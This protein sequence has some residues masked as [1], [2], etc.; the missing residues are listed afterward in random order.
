MGYR[1]LR[2]I[3]EVSFV[4]VDEA[5]ELVEKDGYVVID[6]RDKLQYERAHIKSSY[7]VPLFVENQDNDIGKKNCVCSMMSVK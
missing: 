6:V 5:K 2:V 7:H 4:N 1:S 3:A